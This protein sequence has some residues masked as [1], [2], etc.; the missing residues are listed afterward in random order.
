MLEVS[1]EV[2]HRVDVHFKHLVWFV[3]W[4]VLDGCAIFE[5]NCVDC[6]CGGGL[7]SP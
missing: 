5:F 4:E 7:C 3:G 6:V 1:S 2:E